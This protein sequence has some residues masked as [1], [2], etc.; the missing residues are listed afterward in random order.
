MSS[1]RAVEVIPN[2]DP[3]IFREAGKRIREMAR[4]ADNF[5]I[6]EPQ[7]D[8]SSNIPYGKTIRILNL[9]NN[10]PMAATTHG[11]LYDTN[12]SDR[13]PQTQ[14]RLVDKGHGQVALQSVDGRYVFTAGFGIAGDVRLTSDPQ[15]AETFLKDDIV[16]V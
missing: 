5:T 7:A 4:V 1:R 6:E 2:Y 14:F 16:P 3:D 12:A 10:K 9:A 8:R 15:Q 13:S 11:L